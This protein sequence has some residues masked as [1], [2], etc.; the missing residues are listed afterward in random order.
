MNRAIEGPFDKQP[1]CEKDIP[2][3]AL[4]L[5]GIPLGIDRTAEKQARPQEVIQEA[6]L[7][8]SAD[9]PIQQLKVDVGGS[10]L[11]PLWA[12]D[13]ENG[14]DAELEK[15]WIAST[16]GSPPV[17]P[18]PRVDK[19]GG[20]GEDKASIAAADM[21]ATQRTRKVQPRRVAQSAIVAIQ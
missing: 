19:L 7:I 2:G 4:K 3:E 15:S 5:A 12:V 14:A 6:I 17:P 9:W 10:L 20:V 16:G 1:L 13:P 8:F 21:L 11:V 18:G